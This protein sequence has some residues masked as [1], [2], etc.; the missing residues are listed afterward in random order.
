MRLLERKDGKGR[1]PAL[2][3]LR[4][5][6]TI[7]RIIQEG[8]SAELYDI[9][10]RSNDMGMCTFNQSLVELCKNGVVDADHALRVAPNADEF[11]LNL[12]GMFTGIDSIDLR[13]EIKKKDETE[14]ESL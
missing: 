4:G 10:K 14:D 3:I 12:E 2:E 5:T 13:T 1:I 7:K 9:M 6:P 8:A 11:R